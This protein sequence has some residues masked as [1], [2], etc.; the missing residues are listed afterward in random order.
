VKVKLNKTIKFVFALVLILAIA[1]V[2]FASA[3]PRTL[4]QLNLL[5]ATSVDPVSVPDS[6]WLPV[7]GNQISDFKL[8]LDGSATTWY[9]LNI[10]YINPTL[11]AINTQGPLLSTFKLTPPTDPDFWAYWAAKGVDG[12]ASMAPWQTVMW[13]I[14]NGNGAMFGLTTDGNGNYMLVDALQKI[15]NPL[16]PDLPL[17]LNG[18]YPTGTYT[19]TNYYD[20]LGIADL[21]I[22]ITLK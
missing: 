14:I 17:R 5:Y 15:V 16:H 9:Y 18:D 22:T 19:F 13:N 8:K 3:T 12:S 11:T 10:K 2:G 6:A 1:S 7:A 20:N 21:A 4:K